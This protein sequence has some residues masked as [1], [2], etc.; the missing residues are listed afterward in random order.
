[1]SYERQ[2]RLRR[3]W[4]ITQ[5]LVCYEFVVGLLVFTCP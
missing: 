5:L 1:M 3:V 2:E 4:Y